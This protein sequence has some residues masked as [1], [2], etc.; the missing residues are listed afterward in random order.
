MRPGGNDGA[1]SSGDIP[2]AVILSKNLVDRA[3]RSLP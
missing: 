2:L 3:V 1:P